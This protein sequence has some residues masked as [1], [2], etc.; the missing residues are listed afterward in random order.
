[1]DL[2]EEEQTFLARHK[3]TSADVL[4]GSLY[5][6]RDHRDI[7]K[8]LRKTLVLGAPCGTGHRLRT[9]AGHCVQCDP[10]KIAFE[11]RHSK[12]GYIYIA[13]SLA[14]RLVKVG[15]TASLSD[16]DRTLRDQGYGGAYDWRILYS[17]WV[18]DYGK[19][20]ASVQRL[21]RQFASPRPYEKDGCEQFAWEVFECPF[22]VAMEAVT[23][24]LEGIRRDHE[25]VMPFSKEYEFA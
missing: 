11:G 6:R 23:K 17:V 19:S 24:V 25:R 12:S 1:M 2:T 22:S 10:K 7:A 15:G 14:T 13:G 16:R 21:L 20:E 3:L 18:D 5:R 4:D 8:E 9:R